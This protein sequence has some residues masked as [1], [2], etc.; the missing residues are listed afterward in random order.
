MNKFDKLYNDIIAEWRNYNYIN[1]RRITS[2]GFTTAIDFNGNPVTFK[3]AT[4]EREPI[5]MGVTEFGVKDTEE[6]FK[7]E[8]HQQTHKTGARFVLW[9]PNAKGYKKGITIDGKMYKEVQ[10]NPDQYPELVARL[11]EYEVPLTI[12]CN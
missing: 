12:N 11:A 7:G 5:M 9:L 3:T 8:T 2:N 4:G 1:G 6:F 10:A